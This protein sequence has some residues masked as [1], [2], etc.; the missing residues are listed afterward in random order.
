MQASC[1]RK[2]LVFSRAKP[3]A[4]P[5]PPLAKP[6]LGRGA[7]RSWRG[8]GATPPHWES[9]SRAFRRGQRGATPANCPS[10]T[11]PD[12]GRVNNASLH[13]PR[14]TPAAAKSLRGHSAAHSPAWV[15]GGGERQNSGPLARDEFERAASGPHQRE[16]RNP[17][18]A[19][20]T[21]TPRSVEVCALSPHHVARSR[22][23]G[24]QQQLPRPL[25]QRA[26]SPPRKGFRHTVRV[27]DRHRRF[28]RVSD[29]RHFR[30]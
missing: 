26:G 15:E 16:R 4:F 3:S 21:A 11:R 2:S 8:E 30:V 19:S 7:P 18:R 25:C 14:S 20:A 12:A 27:G 29:R 1:A 17:P 24:Y 5:L 28:A 13:L 6:I 10:V 23:L 9:S 22:R